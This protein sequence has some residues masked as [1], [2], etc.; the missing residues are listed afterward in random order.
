M[1]AQKVNLG[2]ADTLIY[3]DLEDSDVGGLMIM[4]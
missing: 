1:F 4:M 2:I 3:K